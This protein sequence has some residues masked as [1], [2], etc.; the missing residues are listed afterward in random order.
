MRAHPLRRSATLLLLAASAAGCVE[1]ALTPV[2]VGGDGGAQGGSGG[3]GG[4]GLGPGP[5]FERFCGEADWQD[6]LEPATEGALHGDYLGVLAQAG[7]VAGTMEGQKLVVSHP[8]HVT[9]I[10]AAFAGEPGR[11]RLR[12]MKSYG[13]TF[14]WPWP[15][16]ANVAEDLMPPVEVDVMAP[17]PEAYVEIDV[18]AAGAFL[19]PTQ[20]YLLVYEHL[21]TEPFLAVEG[22]AAAERDAERDYSRAGIFFPPTLDGGGIGGT[23]EAPSVNYRAYVEGESFC[24]VE[25]GARLFTPM[26]SPFGDISSQNVTVADVDGDGHDDLVAYPAGEAPRAYLGDGQGAFSGAGAPTFDAPWSGLLVFADVDNDGDRDAF[27][28]TF[29]LIDADD[30]FVDIVDGADCNDMDAGVRPGNAEV[31]GN[32]KDDDCDG[33]ADDGT[34]TADDDGDGAS[35][36][37]GD[38]DDTRAAS[39]PGNAELLD[40]LDNDCDGSVDEDQ[41]HRL[42]LNDGAGYVVAPATGVERLEPTTSA[43]FSDIDGDG[44]LDLYCGNWLVRHPGNQPTDRAVQDRLLRGQGDGTFA[45]ETEIAGVALPKALPAFHTLWNDY[46]HDGDADLFV[47]N[48]LLQPNQLWQNQGDGSFLD[49]ANTLGMAVDTVLGP[50]QSIYPGGHTFGADFGDIDGDGDDDFYIAN[51]S[52][53]RFAPWSDPS[54]LLL[55]AGAPSFHFD[56]HREAAG[57]VYDEGDDTALF[58]DFD[59]DMDLDLVVASLYESHFSRLYRNDGGTFVDVTYEAGAAVRDATSAVWADLDEDGDLDLLVADRG[60]A[61]YLHLFENQVGQDRGWL[62]LDLVGTTTNRDG[63]GARVTVS[64][65]GIT[66]ARELRAGAKQSSHWLHFGLDDAAAVDEVTVR[67]LGGATETFTGAAPGGRYRLV[68]GTGAASALP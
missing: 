44:A 41:H 6:S 17:D 13:R 19:L 64:A 14:P 37:A 56:D 54:L 18:S 20:H 5:D 42:L 58:G 21:Q 46:D 45:D 25:P 31:A 60:G 2:G 43:A 32:G 67:W 59:N 23:P 7:I 34:S 9:K 50:Q 3:S 36:A 48:Y 8:F 33:V 16:T 66:Q 52:H 22:V 30:D 27:A 38:C 12:L 63:V 11:V 35:I 39:F 49:V 40:G 57:L 55:G 65:K 1:E 26:A 68:E 28:A 53:P 47:G 24:R 62:M 15:D 51:L 61:P 10:R 29:A 4:E